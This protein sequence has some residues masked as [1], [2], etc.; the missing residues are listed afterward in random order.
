MEF[1]D[2]YPTLC[3]LAGVPVAAHA[4]GTSLVPVLKD[5]EVSVKDAAV[6]QFLRRRGGGQ[7]MGYSLRTDRFRYTE[8]VDRTSLEAVAHELYDHRTDPGE[9][10][11]VAATEP[12][13]VAALGQKLWRTIPRPEPLKAAAAGRPERPNIVVF[14]ADDWS[15]PHAGAYGDKV[16]ETPNFDRIA[17][18]GLLFT[19]AF[20]S[21]P[22]CTP[23]R[24]SIL[25]G[26]HHWR[27]KEADSLGGSLREEFPVYTDLL[28]EAGY[29]V[30][31][32]GKGLWPSKHTF[33]NRD[34][35]GDRYKSFDAFLEKRKPGAPICFWYGGRD[36]HRPYELGVGQRG[37]IELGSIEVPAPL[38]DNEV[39]RGDLAD[40]YWCVRRFDREVGAVLEKLEAMGELDDTVIVISGDNGMPFPRAK[41][42][43]YDLGTRVPLAVRWGRG[44]GNE[45]RRVE[46]LVSLCDLA[47]TFL[48][49]AGLRGVRAMTGQ[50]LVSLFDGEPWPR[51][52]VLTGMERHVFPN[53]SRAL[54]T[55]DHLYIRNETPEAWNTGEVEGG[56]REYDFATEPWPTGPG[57][58]SYNIDPSPTKQSLRLDPG[59]EEAR[60]IFSR[61]PA[62]ELYDLRADPDQLHNL[63]AEPGSRG[64]LERLRRQLVTGLR[65]A[66][67]PR[68]AR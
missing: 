61:R 18:E 11:N 36:P 38:P 8:W 20:A 51:T 45:G 29:H 65:S 52:S 41:A 67:D 39:V 26:Q 62:E 32:F 47:P 22:S 31:R 13:T 24:A 44:I 14:M 60:R 27:L 35:F 58:F 64:L 53:P 25:T 7:L 57:A 40:Y 66:G 16:A 5:P 4:E 43:L 17:R 30:G 23:S 19:H 68:V 49:V 9:T 48:E 1:V 56:S 6:S 28:A 3:E 10:R 50:S 34:S 54:R 15:Y 42:T 33:R 2:V 12:A 21:T 63:A 37:G 59:T 46:G 55:A